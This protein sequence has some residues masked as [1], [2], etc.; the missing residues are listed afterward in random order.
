MED[1]LTAAQAAAVEAMSAKVLRQLLLSALVLG[2]L[3]LVGVSGATAWLVSRDQNYTNWVNHTY[4][5]ERHLSQMGMMFERAEA[6]RRGYLLTHETQYLGTY[7][8]AAITLRQEIDTVRALTPDN[9]YQQQNTAEMG[10]LLTEKLTA[11]DQALQRAQSG[12][13]ADASA[14]LSRDQ[15]LVDR[16]RSLLT[17]MIDEENRLLHIRTDKQ[18]LNA[19]WLLTGV[20]GSGVVLAVLAIGAGVLVRRYAADL[21]RSQTALKTLNEGLEQ[22]VRDRTADLTRANDEIQRFA[23]IVSHDLRSP[24]V[25]V[26]GFTSELEIS[27]KPLQEMLAEAERVAPHIVSSDTRAAVNEDL[28]EAIGFIRSSTKKMDRLINAILKLSREG[29]R[30]LA[31]ERVDV[32]AVAQ[33]VTDSLKHQAVER[34]AEFEIVR[35]LPTL[36][37]DRLALEQVLSNL[38][39]NALK[40]L[41]PGRP[42][43]IVVRGWKEGARIIYEVADNGRGVDPKDHERIFDLFRR[44][45]LQDQPGEGIGLAHVRALVYRLG[46][47]IAIDSEL[48]RGATFRLSLPAKITRDEGTP[49]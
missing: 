45:G 13:Q 15:L 12:D 4:T 9:A 14:M 3:V 20:L 11:M 48:D 40:Y 1:K 37:S 19:D 36:V 46:G 26:M 32:E 49:A 28:P 33:A 43:H 18:G 7:R 42:G 47:T 16:M 21:G 17:R 29:R 2:F 31:P 22:A 10:D 23:Y 35:P 25:N 5:V 6:A 8:E 44:S 38:V 27:L 24:L 39:E 41:K 34:G 30:T